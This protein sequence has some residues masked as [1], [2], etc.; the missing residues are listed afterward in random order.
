MSDSDLLIITGQSGAAKLP[1]RDQI[2]DYRGCLGTLTDS[3]GR[4]IWTPALPGADAATRQDWY[5]ILRE[6]GATHI[7]FGPFEAGPA[8]PGIVHWDNPDWTLDHAAIRALCDEMLS[9]PSASGYGFVP[10]IF[11][12]GGGGNPLPRLQVMLRTLTVA[13]RG[14]E[15]SVMAVPAWEPVVGAWRS[16]EVSWALE[17]LHAAMPDVL[18]GYHGSPARLVGSSNC[19]P[20]DTVNCT[21]YGYEPDDPWKGG[22][23]AFYTEHGGQFIEMALY[24]T[25]HGDELYRACTCATPLEKFGHV[26]S[27]W[28]N[29]AED[30]IARIGAGYNGWRKLKLCLYEVGTY[31]TTRGWRTAAESIAQSRNCRDLVAAKWGVVIGFGDGIP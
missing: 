19:D 24:Q 4:C 23:A 16:Y 22:E 6:N 27:C 21:V 28:L 9:V 2:L 5:R 31:E 8:Y 26:D 7:P 25:P 11:A 29:R 17:N 30:Y 18:I 12:D 1:G 20:H 10:V 3:L 14:I 13:L 15:G